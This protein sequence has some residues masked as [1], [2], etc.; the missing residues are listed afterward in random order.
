[1]LQFLQFFSR[2]FTWQ[3]IIVDFDTLKCP[4]LNEESNE[5]ILYFIAA[6]IGRLTVFSNNFEDNFSKS[7]QVS[8]IVEH[9]QEN[10][11]KPNDDMNEFLRTI[12]QTPGR[13]SLFLQWK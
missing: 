11:L 5:I 9:V 1:M 12:L 3:L 6:K 2:I 13:I 4:T 10:P 7:S 8:I